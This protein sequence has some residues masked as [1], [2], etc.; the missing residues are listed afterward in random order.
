M[1]IEHQ[2]YTI[3]GVAQSWRRLRRLGRSS[4]SYIPYIDLSII[5]ALPLFIPITSLSEKYLN[6]P[7]F[8]LEQRAYKTKVNLLKDTV[9][10]WWYSD[11]NLRQ[12]EPG[13]GAFTYGVI[14][15]YSSSIKQIQIYI[16]KFLLP[17]MFLLEMKSSI[18][19]TRKAIPPKDLFKDVGEVVRQ[20]AINRQATRE[21]RSSEK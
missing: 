1:F 18:E 15:I 13:M 16:W 20:R 7:T 8:Q 14:L 6:L 5:C 3:Y 11:A 4:S 21:K 17:V 10:K 12:S 19:N 2:L 9:N